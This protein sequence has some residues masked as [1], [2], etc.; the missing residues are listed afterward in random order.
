MRFVL[1]GA[2]STGKSTLI[3]KLVKHY[4]TNM[5]SELSCVASMQCDGL[6]FTF[7]R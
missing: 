2:E 4:R 6:Y 7:C 5:V 1:V 3:G